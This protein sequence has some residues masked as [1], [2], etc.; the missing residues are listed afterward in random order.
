MGLVRQKN[1]L[2]RCSMCGKR[3][4]EPFRLLCMCPWIVVSRAMYQEHWIRDLVRIGKW[5]EAVINLLRFPVGT[6]L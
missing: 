6:S 3:L 1:K 4:I 2:Y 5:R